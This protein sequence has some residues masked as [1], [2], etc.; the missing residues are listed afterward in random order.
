M[1]G[2]QF[3]AG[4][5]FL[6]NHRDSEAVLKGKTLDVYRYLFRKGVAQG[7][8][9]V[10]NG[11]KLSSA[12]VA[13]YHLQKLLEAG[14]VEERPDGYVVNRTLFENLVRIRRVI[15]PVQIAYVVFFCAAMALLLTI[16]RPQVIST[17]YAFGLLVILSALGIAVREAFAAWRGP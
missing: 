11:L 4:L 6:S 16:F 13:H 1:R 14:L 10:Q 5:P 12:S 3:E 7:P 15:L 8:H 2:P 9:D 17:G